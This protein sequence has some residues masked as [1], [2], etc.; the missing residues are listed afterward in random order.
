MLAELRA[1]GRLSAATR[2]RLARTAFARTAAYDAEIVAWLDAPATGA[3]SRAAARLPATLTLQ[4]ERAQELRYGEN[5]HQ[6][7]ARYRRVG[8]VR[9]VGHASSSTA[10][11]S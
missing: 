10:A 6:A 11:R 7:A 8:V 9:L 2:R 5:P 4:L 3:P 1:G